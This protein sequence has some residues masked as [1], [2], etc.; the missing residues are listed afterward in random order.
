MVMPLARSEHRKTASAAIS[1]DCSMLRI[2]PGDLGHGFFR[3]APLAFARDDLRHVAAHQFGF[4][5]GRADHDAGHAMRRPFQRHATGQAE[6]PRLGGA[7]GRIVLPADG[8]R[9]RANVFD[10]CLTNVPV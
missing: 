3:R 1:C 5:P 10:Y 2:A 8:S 6:Q 9:R 7:I 4:D